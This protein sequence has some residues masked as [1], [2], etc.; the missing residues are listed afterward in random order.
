METFAKRVRFAR[1]SIG[2]S[3]V[4]VAA[5]SGLRQPDISKIELG[6]IRKTTGLLGLARALKVSPDWLE[7]GAG[8]MDPGNRTAEPQWDYPAFT[9]ASE[10]QRI[11][12]KRVQSIKFARCMLILAGDIAPD[13]QPSDAPTPEPAPA[14]K[15]TPAIVP[16]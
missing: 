3:Q 11:T 7:R 12:D 1:N 2:L 5:L 8:P 9:L 6:R 13:T 16:R 4:E 10:I 14:T 15:N